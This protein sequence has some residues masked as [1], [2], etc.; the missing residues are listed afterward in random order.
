MEPGGG[1][2]APQAQLEESANDRGSRRCSLVE[3][4]RGIHRSFWG[5]AFRVFA[6]GIL[7]L[8]VQKTIMAELEIRSILSGWWWWCYFFFAAPFLIGSMQIPK[9]FPEKI[10]QKTGSRPACAAE[11]DRFQVMINT[12]ARLAQSGVAFAPPPSGRPTSRSSFGQQYIPES[13]AVSFFFGG[14]FRVHR[15]GWKH[16]KG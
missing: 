5:L 2:V 8:A 10:T 12:G 6:N 7:D 9:H 1:Q 4:L 11:L 14:G 13:L 15:R 3:I 16:P